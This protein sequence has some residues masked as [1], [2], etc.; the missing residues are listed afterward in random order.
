[1]LASC[2]A[3]SGDE[4][5]TEIAENAH[6]NIVIFYVDDLGYGDVGSYGAIGIETPSIDR[7][8]ANGVRFTDA[9]S[10]AAIDS[11]KHLDYWL[12]KNESGREFLVEESVSTLSLRKG[13]WK[14]ILPF[15]GRSG[16]EWVADDKDIEGGFLTEPQLYDLDSDI[17]E[18]VNLAAQY[19]ELVMELDTEAKRII[20]ADTYR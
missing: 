18:Q 8:A 4:R 20:V 14:Y 5:D 11:H 2:S 7:L 17:G 10:S 6:P 16:L 15:D 19:P 1:M 13:D 12:G 9:H 3:D